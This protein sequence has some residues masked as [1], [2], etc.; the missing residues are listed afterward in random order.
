M[1]FTA[2]EHWLQHLRSIH[3]ALGRTGADNGV[4]FVDEQHDL[5]LGLGDLLEHRLQS[6]FELS[7]VL[8]ARHERTHIERKN[9]LVL[10]AFRNVTADDSLGQP[11]D[12]GRLADAGLANKDRVVLGTARQHLDDPAH[13]LVASNHRIQLALAGKLGEIAP[14]SR[15]R[16]V[17]GLGILRGDP[18]VTAH[19]RQCLVEHVFGDSEPLQQLR[20]GRSARLCREGEQQVLG[21]DELVLQPRR[22]GLGRVDDQFHARGQA[23]V[24]AIRLRDRLQ[25]CARLAC[26]AHRV[27]RDLPQDGRHDAAG[28]LHQRDEQMFRSHLRVVVLGGEVLRCEEGFLRFFSQFVQIHGGVHA[29]LCVLLSSPPS[30][31]SASKYSRSFSLSL[32]GSWTSTRAYKSPGSSALPTAGIP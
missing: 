21:A 29:A 17:G 16:L 27:E 13:F 2:G 18:L 22:F 20:G 23:H 10:E 3:R 4:Q 12:D 26:D 15:E 32:V 1:Q 9:L 24:A 19:F 25:K 30:F 31:L 5:S 14:I 6:L 8:R 11:L 28:L 7:P